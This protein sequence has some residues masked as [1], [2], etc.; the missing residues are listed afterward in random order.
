MAAVLVASVL[1]CGLIG[2][3]PSSNPLEVQNGTTLPIA[4]IVDGEVEAVVPPQAVTS[5]AGAD[6]PPMPWTIS[7]RTPTGRQLGTVDVAADDVVR[8]TGPNGEESLRGAGLRIDLSCG[9]LEIWVGPP[10]HGPPPG[11][12]TAG[13]CA[14]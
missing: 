14:P 10:M 4:V 8:T 1:G 3:P 5:I 11:P 6:L 7:A 9:R 12:G 13:D 2:G